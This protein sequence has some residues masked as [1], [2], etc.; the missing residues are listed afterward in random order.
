MNHFWHGM[1]KRLA[2]WIASREP[3]TKSPVHWKRT[4]LQEL[5]GLRIPNSKMSWMKKTMLWFSLLKRTITL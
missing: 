4:K 3:K 5:P 2:L 1:R